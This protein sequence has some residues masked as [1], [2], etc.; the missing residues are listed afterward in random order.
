MNVNISNIRKAVLF[1]AAASS[2]LLTLTTYA[3][4]KPQLIPAAKDD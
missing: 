4:D 3:A 1:T 2:L